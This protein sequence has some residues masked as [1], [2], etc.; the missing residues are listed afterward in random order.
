MEKLSESL[1]DV[2]LDGCETEENADELNQSLARGLRKRS[3][4]IGPQ[5]ANING[6]LRP[7][8]HRNAKQLMVVRAFG[9]AIHIAEEDSL[10]NMA[11]KCESEIPDEGTLQNMIPQLPTLLLLQNK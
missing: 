7:Y 2:N 10:E 6:S 11:I 4:I 5:L 1:R 3:R 8:R 9:R